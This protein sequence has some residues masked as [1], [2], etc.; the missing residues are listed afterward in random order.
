ML[1]DSCGRCCEH[2]HRLLHLGKRRMAVAHCIADEARD[3]HDIVLRVLHS[4]VALHRG[5]QQQVRV[6]HWAEG[7]PR[8]SGP[9][10]R[11]RRSASL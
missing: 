9:S 1:S 7:V 8:T 2:A 5:G 10:S 4:L 11:A 6:R 3:E